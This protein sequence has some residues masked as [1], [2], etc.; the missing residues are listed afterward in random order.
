MADARVEAL[1]AENERLRARIAEL[2]GALVHEFATPAGWGLTGSEARLL[3]ALTT[4]ELLTKEAAMTVL[5]PNVDADGGPQ[6]KIVDV[7]ICKMRKKLEPVGVCIETVWG[8]GYRLGA[9]SKA[10][11]AGATA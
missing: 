10:I 9:A 7:F 8:R 2:E 6:P 4:R 1:E 5:Y 11:V 3:G